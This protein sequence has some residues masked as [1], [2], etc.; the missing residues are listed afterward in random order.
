MW[1]HD[2]GGREE[3]WGWGQGWLQGQSRGEGRD[4]GG[5][6]GVKATARAGVV[7][8]VGRQGDGQSKDAERGVWSPGASP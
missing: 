8:A 7:R 4:E 5:G 2:G 1:W 3:G 6:G